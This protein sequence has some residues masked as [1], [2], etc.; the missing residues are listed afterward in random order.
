MIRKTLR[1]FIKCAIWF[2]ALSIVWV[3]LY[4]WLPVPYTPLM[5][6]RYFESDKNYENKHDWVALD[7]ISKELQLAVICSEDQN[8]VNHHGFDFNAIEKAY[9]NNK[10]GKRL[11]GGSTI[12]QQ[13][14][15]NIFLWPGR[16]WFR[17]GLE[18]YFTFLI[19]LLWPKERILEVYLNSIEMGNGVFGAEAAAQYWFHKKAKNLNRY[20]AASLAVILPN[21]RKYTATPRSNY[22]ENRKQWVI[23]QMRYYGTFTLK[24]KTHD[25]TGN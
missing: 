2:F 20:E 9:K 15:K 4:R 17:K 12:S 10:K 19:E 13:T 22:L 6:I 23:Q 24:P 5:T 7:A 14:A 16:S 18:T 3:L 1:F 11:K 25:G 8:F 21:P